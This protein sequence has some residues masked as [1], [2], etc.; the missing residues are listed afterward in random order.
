MHEHEVPTHVQAEDRVLLWFTFPQ[1]IALAVVAALG[2]GVYHYAPFGSELVRVLMGAAFA[3]VGVAM[4]AG[5]VGGRPLPAVLAD[6]LRFGVGARRFMGPVMQLVRAEPPTPPATNEQSARRPRT[7]GERMPRVPLGWFR[8]RDR[9]RPSKRE[10]DEAKQSFVRK[11]RI[12]R[13]RFLGR[14]QT[15]VGGAS[16]LAAMSVTVCTPPLAVAQ[17][18]SLQPTLPEEIEF[19]PSPLIE[20]RR[21]FIE[22]LSVTES[23]ATVV[24]K[25]AADLDLNVQAFG[26]ADGQLLAVNRSVQLEEGERTTQLL[27][28]SGNGPSFTFAWLDEYNEAGAVALAGEQLPFP[29][30]NSEGE[31]CDLAISR[32]EW[33]PG[34]LSGAVQ[35]DCVD[36]INEQVQLQTVSGLHNLSQDLVLN[37]EVKSVSGTIQVRAGDRTSSATFIA[38]G[39]TT[40]ELVMGSEEATLAVSL[41]ATLTADLQIALPPLVQLAHV[42]QRTETFSKTVSLTD[43]ESGESV[44][45][46]VT[47]QVVHPARVEARIVQRSPL[48]KQ[49]SEELA[50]STSIAADAPYESLNEPEP[51]NTGSTQTVVSGSEL[52]DLLSLLGWDLN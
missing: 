35:S 24:L 10:L 31:L 11:S 49:R 46:T 21:L 6:L 23:E 3:A 1:L 20:G 28:L 9:K 26:G 40:F 38:D 44:S 41:S 8:K 14:W 51:F 34:R 42:P 19:E 48:T 2:Y 27:P 25:A 18:P 45:Q 37:A 13:P 33:Q 4:V 52:T 50:L 5:K 39:V 32:L 16:V 43:P 36:S 17:E 47:F 12:H 15:L 29:L 30:P 7:R 22:R